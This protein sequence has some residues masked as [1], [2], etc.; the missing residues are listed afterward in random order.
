MSPKE[1][2]ANVTTSQIG[3]NLHKEKKAI[4]KPP[5]EAL[6]PSSRTI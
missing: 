5:N 4:K 1:V 6:K 3:Q 2:T